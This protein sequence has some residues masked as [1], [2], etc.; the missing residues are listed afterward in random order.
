MHL[1]ADAYRKKHNL[2]REYKKL[3]DEGWFVKGTSYQSVIYHETGHMVSDIYGIDG[4]AIMKD[5]LGTTSTAETL[6]WC[7]NNLS[8]YSFK[9]DGT[10]I[11]SEMFS[12]FY[13]LNNPPKEVVDFMA[14]CDKMIVD[15][16]G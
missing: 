3:S 8:E 1:N 6:L 2:Q 14:K 9:V 10:E 7:K 13:G 12:A 5:V 15:W 4:L 16:R 11:V